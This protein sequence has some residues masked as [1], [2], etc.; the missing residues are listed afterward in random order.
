MSERR[1]EPFESLE[2]A[3]QPKIE[4]AVSG[5]PKGESVGRP[6]GSDAFLAA[7]ETWT[8]RRLRALKRGPKPKDD[9]ATAAGEVNC[10]VT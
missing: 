10:T 1:A 5:I 6:V 9:G 8:R 4:G 7:L 3:G 2:F